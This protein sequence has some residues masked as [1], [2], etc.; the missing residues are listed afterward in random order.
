MGLDGVLRYNMS[1]VGRGVVLMECKMRISRVIDEGD[2][3]G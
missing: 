3:S 1:G 2:S